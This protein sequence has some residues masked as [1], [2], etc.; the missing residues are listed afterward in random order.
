MYLNEK[1]AIIKHFKR[2]STCDAYCTRYKG[3]ITARKLF[4]LPQYIKHVRST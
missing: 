1:G 2:L 3:P 4:S